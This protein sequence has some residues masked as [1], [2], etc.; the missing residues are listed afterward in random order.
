MKDPPLCSSTERT[1][2]MRAPK[3]KSMQA[4]IQ[5]SM[6]VSPSALGV[7]VVTVLN[8]FTRTR[9]RVTSSAIRPG[10]TS[11]GIRNEIQETITN[12]P[13]QQEKGTVKYNHKQACRSKK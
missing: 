7:L 8:M 5:A 2:S 13:A 6:A 11:M 12:R 3:T 1:Y 4:S 9:K 10:I